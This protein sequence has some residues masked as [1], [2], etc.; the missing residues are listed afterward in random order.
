[1][2]QKEGCVANSTPFPGAK[3]PVKTVAVRMFY[4]QGI[5]GNVLDILVVRTWG[6]E[7]YSNL[8]GRGHGAW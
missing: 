5:L 2:E 6:R 1:M 4:N 8:V 7:C 3:L